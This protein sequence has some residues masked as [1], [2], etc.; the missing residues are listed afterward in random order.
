MTTFTVKTPDGQVYRGLAP[1][2]LGNLLLRGYE[3]DWRVERRADGKWSL[4][5]RQ[6]MYR[7]TG[8]VVEGA[9]EE[10]AAA[11]ALQQAC[12]DPVLRR[13]FTIEQEAA[14]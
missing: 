14:E 1:A 10:E 5:M 11:A 12:S 2:Q 7:P 9:N 13:G 3:G 8:I 4:E 6:R